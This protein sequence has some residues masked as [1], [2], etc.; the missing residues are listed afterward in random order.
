MKTNTTFSDAV[1]YVKANISSEKTQHAKEVL[2]TH[3]MELADVDESLD[4]DI[5]DLMEEYGADHDLAEGWWEYE[6][7]TEDILK[8]L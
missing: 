3:N 8:E 2:T 6:G 7:T 5:N 4:D 1:A